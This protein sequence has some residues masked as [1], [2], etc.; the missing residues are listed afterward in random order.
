MRRRTKRLGRYHLTERIAFGG[1]AE[2]FRAFTFEDDG[3]KRDVAIKRLLPHYV[4]DQQFITMLTDEFKLV[5]HLK[6]PN[7]AEVFELVEVDDSLLIAMEYVDGKDLRSTVEK[8]KQRRLHLALDD[9]AYVLARALDG[10]HHAHVARDDHDE[11][12][13][14]VHRD[15]SP[16]NILVAYDGTVKLCDFGIAK[17]SHNR[18]Q[19]KTGIIKGKVKYMSPEQAFGRKLDWRSDLFSAGSVLYELCTD[20]APFTASNE[21]DLIFAVRD[22]VPPPCRELNPDIPEQLGRIIEKSMSRS[23]SA[24][25]QTALEFRDALLRFLRNYNPKY[26]R[27]KLSRFMKRAWNE[28]IERD[29]RAMEEFVIDGAAPA[30]PESL[31]KNLIADALGPGAAFNRFSPQPTKNVEG[32]GSEVHELR[33]EIIDTENQ[34]AAASG[35]DDRR[36]VKADAP[37]DPIHDEKTQVVNTKGK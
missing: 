29:L 34:Q 21:I 16:S 15:F 25:Y 24:R 35:G 6:H 14:I 11:P 8:A 28:E 5:S 4:E 19:T 18:I 22:A 26:R 3:F 17:A 12:L 10:L 30:P 23:R 2:I 27:T 7:I 31:G 9:V 33:T 36:T 13:K 20:A 32:G 37:H 1:M